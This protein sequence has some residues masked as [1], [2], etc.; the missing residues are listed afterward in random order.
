[1]QGEPMHV[2]I[3]V[4]THR[5]R[6]PLTGRQGDPDDGSPTALFASQFV[7]LA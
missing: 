7:G 1:M 3:P 6:R 2:R 4:L 5:I